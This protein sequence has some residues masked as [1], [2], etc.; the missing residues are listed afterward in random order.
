[1]TGFLALFIER[2][3]KNENPEMLP[4]EAYPFTITKSIPSTQ[5]STMLKVK[6]CQYCT[7]LIICGI[8][9]LRF[10]KND[11]LANLNFGVYGIPLLHI[12]KKI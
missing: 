8:K 2:G 6:T 11:K 5:H 9:F 3:S 12:V 10:N 1:M 4:L 7:T